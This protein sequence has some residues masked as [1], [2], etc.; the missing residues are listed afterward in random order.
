PP[1][2]EVCKRAPFL[3]EPAAA[4]GSRHAPDPSRSICVEMCKPCPLFWGYGLHPVQTQTSP[5]KV[6]IVT[7]ISQRVRIPS[8]HPI[9]FTSF[10][11]IN[12]QSVYADLANC[13]HAV[14]PRQGLP[15]TPCPS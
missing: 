10:F 15:L 6:F 13:H 3:L 8:A 4:L 9:R 12:C 11:C 5:A 1:L 14:R 7:A 2:V